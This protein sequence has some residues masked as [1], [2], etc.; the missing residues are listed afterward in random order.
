MRA[1]GPLEQSPISATA[2]AGTMGFTISQPKRIDVNELIV[3]P[4]AQGEFPRV[5][6]RLRAYANSGKQI[7]AFPI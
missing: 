7:P 2:I 6:E 4:T 1:A 5:G 3:R